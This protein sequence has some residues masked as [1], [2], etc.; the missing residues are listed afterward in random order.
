MRGHK[1]IVRTIKISPDSKLA[2]TVSSDKTVKLW[3]LHTHKVLKN[4]DFHKDDSVMAMSCNKDFTKMVTGSRKGEIFFTDIA[5]SIYCRMDNLKEESIL[6]LALSND[7]QY[8]F[9]TTSKNKLIEY[10]YIC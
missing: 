3:D 9:A 10:V 4:F 1:D 2:M 7:S 5:K 8:I 6:S